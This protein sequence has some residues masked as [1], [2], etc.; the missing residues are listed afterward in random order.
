MMFHPLAR[1][2]CCNAPLKAREAYESEE[3]IGGFPYAIVACTGCD[4][5][6]WS[7]E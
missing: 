3:G 2:K 5:K 1:S 7:V 6:Q 4:K